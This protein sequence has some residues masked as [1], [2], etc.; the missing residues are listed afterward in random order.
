M[1]FSLPR[2][3]KLSFPWRFTLQKECIFHIVVF[4]HLLGGE[5]FLR[6]GELFFLPVHYIFWKRFLSPQVWLGGLSLHLSIGI[7]WAYCSCRNI[8]VLV[9]KLKPEET[10]GP[11]LCFVFCSKLPI[12]AECFGHFGWNII[13]ACEWFIFICLFIFSLVILAVLFFFY[14]GSSFSPSK[15]FHSISK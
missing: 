13:D 1:G 3:W 7:Q 15:L 9:I 14:F 12:V 6:G 5:L 10:G 11:K 4:S 2:F 8:S